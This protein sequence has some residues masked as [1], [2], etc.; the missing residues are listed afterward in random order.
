MSYPSF[1][2]VFSV[3]IKQMN[4]FLLFQYFRCGLSTVQ[5]KQLYSSLLLAVC[6]TWSLVNNALTHSEGICFS[7]QH[8]KADCLKNMDI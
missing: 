4:E 3:Q 5:T 1:D 6:T 8:Q 7:Q 2:L